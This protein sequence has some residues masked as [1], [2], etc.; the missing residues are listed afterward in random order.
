MCSLPLTHPCCPSSKGSQEQWA[1]AGAKTH[2]HDQPA[3]AEARQPEDPAQPFIGPPLQGEPTMM[4]H[5]RLASQWIIENA[6]QFSAPV[7]L[8]RI[9]TMEEGDM[10]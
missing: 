6:D 8:P 10:A 5:Q 4:V 9:L 2:D 1:P 3:K 7:L